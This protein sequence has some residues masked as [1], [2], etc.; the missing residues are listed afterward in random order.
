MASRMSQVVRIDTTCTDIARSSRIA[1]LSRRAPRTGARLDA[2][3]EAMWAGSRAA[4]CSPPPRRHETGAASAAPLS[5]FRYGLIVAETGRIDPVPAR[6]SD[7]C[8]D[9]PST[10]HAPHS[11]GDHVPRSIGAPR[12]VRTDRG[13]ESTKS[14]RSNPWHPE[15]GNHL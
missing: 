6:R 2:L 7:R 9:G 14:C 10:D 15:T 4:K 11:I 3:T 5:P 1:T 13:V 8:R 12:L